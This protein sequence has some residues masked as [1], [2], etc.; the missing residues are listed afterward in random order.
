MDTVERARARANCLHGRTALVLGAVGELGRDAASTLASLGARV[1]VA[2]EDPAALEGQYGDD[3]RFDLSM[4]AASSSA[5]LEALAA[6][7]PEVDIVIH[8]TR[9]AA[10]GARARREDSGLDAIR[11]FVP[12]MVRRRRGSIIALACSSSRTSG[13]RGLAASAGRELQ[14]AVRTLAS[15]LRPFGVRVNAVAPD[16]VAPTMAV[17][18]LASDSSSHVTGA[19]L[20]MER[21]WSALESLDER[22]AT[23]APPRPL[24]AAPGVPPRGPGATGP[25]LLPLPLHELEPRMG[26]E[27]YE[28]RRA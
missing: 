27:A 22:P 21:G 1:V 17:A 12:A 23:T 20:A 9:A 16:G 13:E 14:G 25:A 6:A 11:H 24:G 7:L 18:F 3:E 8:R 26:E 28:R 4:V 15:E 10:G 5:D 2:D 19:V